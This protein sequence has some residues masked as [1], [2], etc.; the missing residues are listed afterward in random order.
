[1]GKHFDKDFSLPGPHAGD[2]EELALDYL[3]ER[4]PGPAARAVESHLATCEDCRGEIERQKKMLALLAGSSLLATP[5]PGLS[6]QVFAALDEAAIADERTAGHP[7]EELPAGRG[8]QAGPATRLGVWQ[9]LSGGF[10]RTRGVVWL[11]AAAAVL[12]VAVALSQ[13][14]G[15][16]QQS[17]DGTDSTTAAVMESQPAYPEGEKQFAEEAPTQGGE[18]S[19]DTTTGAGAGSPPLEPSPDERGEGSLPIQILRVLHVERS[20]AAAWPPGETAVRLAGLTGLAPV[21]GSTTADPPTYV[22]R[23]LLTDLPT[24]QTRLAQAGFLVR[25]G[26]EARA[27]DGVVDSE[28]ALGRA[29][30]AAQHLP[31][32]QVPEEGGFRVIDTTGGEDQKFLSADYLLLALIVS[33]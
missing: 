25:E 12:L 29:R 3:A 13:V 10:R 23:T 27:E 7:G 32:L 4:L 8:A 16:T 14:D 28:T 15:L 24:V 19:S 31:L 30:A 17:E 2:W 6:E 5:P 26:S 22:A 33:E 20:P 11:P 21:P 1:M 18:R 9:R